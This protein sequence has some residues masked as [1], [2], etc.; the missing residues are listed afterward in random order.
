MLKGMVFLL[1]SRCTFIYSCGPPIPSCTGGLH[2]SLTKIATW[3]LAGGIILYTH[4]RASQVR[5]QGLETIIYPINFNLKC[6]MVSILYIKHEKGNIKI[7][8]AFF[9]NCSFPAIITSFLHDLI[10]AV[11]KNDLSFDPYLQIYLIHHFNHRNCRFV[12][13]FLL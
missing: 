10:T 8:T 12:E 4:G 2:T 3:M 6:V 13:I 5:P 9:F 7:H 11:L 1:S